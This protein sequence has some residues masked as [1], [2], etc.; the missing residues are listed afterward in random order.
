[1]M[2]IGFQDASHKTALERQEGGVDGE[3]WRRQDA[4]RKGRRSEGR[5]E[6]K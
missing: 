1:M 4:G 6:R 3:N 2:S 5:R